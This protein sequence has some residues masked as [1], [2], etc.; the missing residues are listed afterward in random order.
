MTRA[1]YPN[2]AGWKDPTVSRDNA[3]K[4]RVEFTRMQHMVLLLYRRGFVG[5]AD[6]AANALHISPFSCRPRCTELLKMGE[7]RRLR[8]DHGNPGRRAWVLAIA[9]KHEPLPDLPD[10]LLDDG[11]PSEQQEWHDYDPEC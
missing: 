10:S 1:G 4:G 3:L 8:V 5:T 7:L 2:R 11:Q 9:L 6:D